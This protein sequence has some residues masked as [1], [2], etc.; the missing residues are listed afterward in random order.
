MFLGQEYGYRECAGQVV[1]WRKGTETPMTD[2]PTRNTWNGRR[3]FSLKKDD[4]HDSI[5][6][7]DPG[8]TTV[9]GLES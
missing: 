3:E 4:G 6:A 8:A 7:K 9:T 5:S 2:Y 1:Q